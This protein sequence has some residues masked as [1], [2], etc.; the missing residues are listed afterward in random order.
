MRVPVPGGGAV[1]RAKRP[2]PRRRPVRSPTPASGGSGLHT[3]VTIIDDDQL[4][5]ERAWG[6]GTIPSADFELQPRRAPAQ[7]GDPQPPAPL[8]PGGRAGLGGMARALA[9]SRSARIAR[10]LRPERPSP[11][12]IDLS[13]CQRP[14]R[15]VRIGDLQLE[16]HPAVVLGDVD[17]LKEPLPDDEPL[18]ER[19]S[20]CGG[21]GV[22]ESWREFQFAAGGTLGPPGPA[23]EELRRRIEEALGLSPRPGSIPSAPATG[24][25]M[26]ATP[27]QPSGGDGRLPGLR[28]RP[29]PNAGA[30]AARF[31]ASL[32]MC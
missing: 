25:P 16:S 14:S 17:L 13:D 10:A 3:A 32:E 31:K 15:R 7:A 8:R 30:G 26:R 18:Q 1:L 29:T 11:S 9:P 27:P 23:P 20:S 6:L 21:T 5:S 12:S 2:W 28:P 19:A 4:S 24:A 22:D